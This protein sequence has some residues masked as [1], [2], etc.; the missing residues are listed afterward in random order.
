MNI[1]NKFPLGVW[2]VGLKD[3]RH[4]L[5]AESKWNSQK[6]LVPVTV[7]VVT[8]EAIFLVG[9]HNTVIAQWGQPSDSAELITDIE[10]LDSKASTDAVI[11]ANRRLIYRDPDGDEEYNFVGSPAADFCRKYGT[12]NIGPGKWD[13]P[14]VKQLK[15]MHQYRKEINKCLMAMEFPTLIMGWYWSSIAVKDND[16]CAW[17]VG[18]GEGSTRYYSRYIIGLYVRAV[19][20]IG[21]LNL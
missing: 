21:N 2:C 11:A 6:G 9:I 18:L 4:K 7:A 16:R 12:I 19:S 10:S 14:T 3:G 8:E 15:I 13:L 20:D 5:I 1:R 17:Y